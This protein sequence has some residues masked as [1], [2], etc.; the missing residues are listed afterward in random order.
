MSAVFAVHGAIFGNFA[1]RVPWVQAHLGLDP[2]SLGL[3][4][5]FPALGAIATMPFAGRLVHALGSR[6]VNRVLMPAFAASLA[7]PALAPGLGLLCAALFLYG[8]TSGMADVSMN[9]QGV[10]VEQGYGRSI[11]TGL[12]GLWSVGGIVGSGFGVLAAHLNVDAR[13]HLAI[14]A[15]VLTV[16]ALIVSSAL[17]DLR[18]DD[19]VE[20]PP[21]F[22]L[23]PRAVLV[24]GLIG[25]CAIFAEGAS[26]DWAAVYLRTVVESSAGVA[27]AAYA[28]FAAAMGVM[29][30]SGDVVVRR[31]GIV[32]TVRVCGAVA[33]AGGAVIVIARH[34]GIAIAGFVLLGLGIAVVLPLVFAVAGRMGAHPAR[35][36]AGV[37]TVS[38]GAGLA[39]PG[40]IGGI[41][42]ATSLSVSFAVVTALTAMIALW[43][44][45]LRR[46]DAPHRV[47]G[48]HAG[49]PPGAVIVDESDGT[50]TNPR[51][52]K[53]R[54]DSESSG[55]SEHGRAS[56]AR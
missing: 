17:L 52:T 56:T 54:R 31:F 11:M 27:A 16:M 23:P 10:S 25:L 14:A 36:I 51:D 33:T 9:A 13:I 48:D 18:E 1:T 53:P 41:A 43:A 20:A 7:L 21:H 42:H 5:L 24:V 29:R 40:L 49:N 34:P 35:S 55:G 30:L 12:H 28:C 3:A 4:L 22:A 39:A 6:A 50:V 46:G 2:G 19:D 37:A 32:R 26:T 45:V 47:D 38:Y 44:G 15:A 8:A